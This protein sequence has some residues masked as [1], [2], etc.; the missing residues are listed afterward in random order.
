MREFLAR[1]LQGLDL[2]VIMIDGTGL[3]DHLILVVLGIDREGRKHILGVREGTTESSEVC[4]SLMRESSSVACRS[5]K[6]GCS[7]STA[8]RAFERRSVRCSE[9]PH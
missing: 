6:R 4:L 2:P 1:S 9:P 5:I 3:G 8:A 7:S